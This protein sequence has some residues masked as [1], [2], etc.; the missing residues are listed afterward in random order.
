[1]PGSFIVLK[2][3]IQIK[4][5]SQNI[6]IYIRIYKYKLHLVSLIDWN[7]ILIYISV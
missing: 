4:L 7:R 6:L 1:M 5:I 2:I 3:Q